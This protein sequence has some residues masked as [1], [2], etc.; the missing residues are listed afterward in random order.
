[1]MDSKRVTT[2]FANAERKARRKSKDVNKVLALVKG[3]VVPLIWKS[4]QQRVRG[5]A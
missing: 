2:L 3:E 5:S 1:M 4:F